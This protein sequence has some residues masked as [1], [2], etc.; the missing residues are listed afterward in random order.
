M[1]YW[2][3][4]NHINDLKPLHVL[5]HDERKEGREES[6]R[7]GG[8]A[9]EPELIQRSHGTPS[10]GCLSSEESW[11]VMPDK[12]APVDMCLGHI[13]RLPYV[14]NYSISESICVHAKHYS[15]QY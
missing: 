2:R 9:G 14:S 12:L 11:R 3:I 15:R 7:D 6:K 1:S 4:G 5:I 10:L 8:T 13:G